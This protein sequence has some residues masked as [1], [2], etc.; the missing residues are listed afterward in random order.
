MMT[1]NRLDAAVLA[2]FDE[3]RRRDEEFA[4]TTI[5]DREHGWT[6]ADLRSAFA[7]LHNPQDWRGPIDAAVRADRLEMMKAAVEFMTATEL[8]VVGG[9]GIDAGWPD[10]WLHI[11]ADGYRQGPAGDH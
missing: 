2:G 6:V 1:E 11:K 3:E 7:E 4:R 5:V 10:G 8:E 9:S